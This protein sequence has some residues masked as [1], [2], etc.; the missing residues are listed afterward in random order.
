M[1][2]IHARTAINKTAALVV[3]TGTH[4]VPN[5]KVLANDSDLPIAT[6]LL[7]KAELRQSCF[8]DLAGARVGRFTV[9]GAAR[10][11]SG[12]WVVRCDCGT[13]STRKTKA[14]KNSKNIQ[15]RCEHC[16]HLAFLK[17]NEQ[18]RRSGR[19]SDIRDF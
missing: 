13:Y 7:T 19:C 1:K 10:D 12:R 18:W 8:I 5:K 2:D 16:R 4:Y 17:R 14:I 11:F 3:G 15:D 6:R 9:I